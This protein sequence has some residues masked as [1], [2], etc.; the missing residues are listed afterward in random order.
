MRRIHDSIQ[1]IAPAL[2]LCAATDL[3]RAQGGGV[4]TP[5]LC[6]SFLHGRRAVADITD[7]ALLRKAQLAAAKLSRGVVQLLAH[8]S[9]SSACSQV[10]ARAHG[11]TRTAP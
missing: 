5:S 7:T 8:I 9:F 6:V 4:F 1:F 10:R 3:L 2:C 11:R